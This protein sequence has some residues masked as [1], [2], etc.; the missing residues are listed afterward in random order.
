[1]PILK[2]KANPAAPFV[3]PTMVDT[4]TDFRARVERLAALNDSLQQLNR[5]KRRLEAE[6]AEM[7]APRMNASVAAL[8]GDPSVDARTAKVKEL[9]DVKRA[10][11]DHETA[12]ELQRRRV[13]QAR[14]AASLAVCEAVKG[15]YGKRV[16]ALVAA[17]ETAREAASR[18][19][20]ITE[21]LEGDG[22]SWTRLGVFVPKL[23]FVEGLAREAREAGYV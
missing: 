15:E 11:V 10:I 16:A 21:Q 22:V 20:E 3:V 9:A 7:P 2:P 4:D 1:M 23:G 18:I 12:I 17:L 6:L 14:G 5:D 8:L 19:A 13:E